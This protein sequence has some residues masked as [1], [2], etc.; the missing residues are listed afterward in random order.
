MQYSE[1]ITQ[2]L[3]CL[4]DLAL[5]LE[6][7]PVLSPKGYV[8]SCRFHGALIVFLSV[9]KSVMSSVVHYEGGGMKF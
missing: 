2:S 7:I 8:V 4:V 3:R 1:Y 9:C 5:G 6:K